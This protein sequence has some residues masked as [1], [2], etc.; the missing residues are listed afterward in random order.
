MSDIE[1]GRRYP[2]DDLL[3]RLANELGVPSAGLRRLD[4]RDSL[5]DLKRMMAGN[6]TWGLAFK[7]MAEAGKSGTLTA[8]DVLR[9]LTE[10]KG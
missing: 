10:K 2:S 7:K 5:G 4:T 9:K 1:L 8:E 6:P 3:E